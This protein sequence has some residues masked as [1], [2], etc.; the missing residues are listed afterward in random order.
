MS[1]RLG[2]TQ[3]GEQ[4]WRPLGATIVVL[5]AVLVTAGPVAATGPGGARDGPSPAATISPPRRLKAGPPGAVIS[6]TPIISP[7]GSRA[8]KVL[9]HSR[10]I[11]GADVAVSGVVV[12]P[13][14]KPPPGGRP[15]VTW[16]HGTHGLADACAPSQALDVTYRIP[17]IRDFIKAGDVVAATDY[18]GLG[19]PGEHPYLVG[20]SEGRGVLDIVRAA[21]QIPGSGASA[22]TL[23][24]GHSQGGQAALFAGQLAASYAPELH[25]LGVV[26]VAPVSD[27]RGF[28]P[29]AA[30]VPL[31]VGYVVM[32]AVGFHAAYPNL[33]LADVLT[34][35]TLAN[36]AIVDQRCSDDLV[37][38]Y[39]Q[40]SPSQVLV[41]NPLDVPAYAAVAQSEVAGTVPTSAPLFVIQGDRDALVPKSLTDQFV[42]R[43][44]ASGDQVQ[45]RVYPGQ[46]HI[47]ARDVSVR[48]VEAWMAARVAG[49]PP[50]STC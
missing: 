20:G 43:A 45:Y 34:P 30:Q 5:A 11:N 6:A 47:G 19:T 21:E 50:P 18:E 23:V 31:L 25:L 41:R 8:W 39:A 22:N 36:L 16:A 35:Q 24:Y 7:A 37:D 42:A 38:Y 46:D 9:Y 10:S 1:D 49:Q 15:V 48:D 17:G 2:A 12:A 32:A 26:A 3:M 29:A 28:L 4:G 27:L 40:F 14:A 44:C 33:N 13:T